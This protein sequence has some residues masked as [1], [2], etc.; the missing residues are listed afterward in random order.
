MATSVE[1][2]GFGDQDSRLHAHLGTYHVEHG[3]NDKGRL[4]DEGNERRSTENQEVLNCDSEVTGSNLDGANR[5][6]S[7][8]ESNEGTLD[9]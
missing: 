3:H 7:T 2:N 5:T 1:E 9:A 4:K 8:A 6:L